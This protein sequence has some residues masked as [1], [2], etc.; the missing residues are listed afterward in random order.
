MIKKKEMNPIRKRVFFRVYDE[1]DERSNLVW[2]N[3]TCGPAAYTFSC[4]PAFLLSAPPSLL[5]A[6][7]SL[8]R[9]KCFDTPKRTAGSH[10][11][12][13]Y[14]PRRRARRS[15]LG[16]DDP[17]LHDRKT[18]E[19]GT[20][21]TPGNSRRDA[22]TEPYL[23]AVTVNE[24]GKHFYETHVVPLLDYAWLEAMQRYGSLCAEMLAATSSDTSVRIGK[25]HSKFSHLSST[26]PA[27]TASNV[28]R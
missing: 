28:A 13:R 2:R 25:F 5:S 4:L 19:F 21:A 24:P 18:V 14:P 15:E 8:L 7:A 16:C 3:I 11:Q 6:I 22:S 12:A 17:L 26:A 10:S 20:A 9:D 23:T 27:M 1:E